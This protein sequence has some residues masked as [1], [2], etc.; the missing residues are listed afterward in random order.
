M[1]TTRPR[2]LARN[3]PE[4]GQAL[5][6]PSFSITLPYSIYRVPVGKDGRGTMDLSKNSQLRALGARG[7]VIREAKR[8]M[9]QDT[10][11]LMVPTAYPQMRTPLVMDA[12]ITTRTRVR[13]D[14]DGVWV[15]LYPARDAVAAHLG[16]NDAEIQTGRVTFVKGELEQMVLTFTGERGRNGSRHEDKPEAGSDAPS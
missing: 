14:D 9:A 10:A 11:W 16:I 8:Q 13:K 15:G 3:A 4:G 5:K 1:T 2:R 7:Y 12:E 6:P